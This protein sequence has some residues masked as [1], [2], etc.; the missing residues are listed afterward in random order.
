MNI[1][2]N[3]VDI[4]KNSRIKKSLKIKGFVKR[5]FTKEEINKS[6]KLN[7]KVN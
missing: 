1:V 2:G 6:K 7:N 3:G 4:I 5:V